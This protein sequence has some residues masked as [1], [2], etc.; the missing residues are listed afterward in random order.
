L[1][2]SQQSEGSSMEYF[3]IYSS[4]LKSCFIEDGLAARPSS[5]EIEFDRI[6]KFKANICPRIQIFSYEVHQTVRLVG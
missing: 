2:L 3:M 6:K 4:T 5:I 1:K